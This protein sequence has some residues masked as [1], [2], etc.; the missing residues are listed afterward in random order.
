MANILTS[1]TYFLMRRHRMDKKDFAIWYF[2][3][4]WIA[5]LPVIILPQSLLE[6]FLSS[7]FTNVLNIFYTVLLIWLV[8]APYLSVKSV[9]WQFLYGIVQI[10]NNMDKFEYNKDSELKIVTSTGFWQVSIAISLLILF[11]HPVLNYINWLWWFQWAGVF[12]WSFI[13]S[14][15]FILLLTTLFFSI[16]E[17]SISFPDIKNK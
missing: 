1:S 6:L 14:W 15:I 8:L 16:Y 10:K 17:S 3:I 9:Y 2:S 4:A 13:V 12:L 7:E 5:L 11:L